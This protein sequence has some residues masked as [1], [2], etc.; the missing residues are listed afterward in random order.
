MAPKNKNELMAWEDPELRI[1][2]IGHRN[3]CTVT[4]PQN[5]PIVADCLRLMAELAKRKPRARTGTE[6]AN[7]ALRE[8]LRY[9]DDLIKAL[10]GQW[11]A[12]K[13]EVDIARRQMSSLEEQL[14]KARDELARLQRDALKVVTLR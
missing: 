8:R 3:A 13:A 7:K 4:H 1:D 6:A 12:A 5:G 9:R 10:T 2:R 11:H 14:K